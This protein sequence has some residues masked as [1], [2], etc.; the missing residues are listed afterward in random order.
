MLLMLW[1]C[2][3]FDPSTRVDELRVMAVQ[4]VPAEITPGALVDINIL[5]AD[6]IGE[7][8]MCWH[9]RTIW[10]KGVWRQSCLQITLDMDSVFSYEEAVTTLSLSV[11]M[12]LTGVIS[13]LPL[14]SFHL[15]ER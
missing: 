10:E 3:A 7:G 9:G 4:S 5:M 11:P 13:Q 12:G 6:P 15:P 1:G 14:S 8:G 2:F